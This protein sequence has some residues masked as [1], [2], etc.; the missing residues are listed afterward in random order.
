MTAAAIARQCG[1]LPPDAP[2]PY[3]APVMASI[4]EPGAAADDRSAPAAARTGGGDAA[5]TSGRAAAGDGQAAG[6]SGRGA[7]EVRPWS[8]N[9]A[10][11]SGQW[12]QAVLQ[13]GA[14]SSFLSGISNSSVQ[15]HVR[16]SVTCMELFSRL[17]LQL[18]DI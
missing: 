9:A 14:A 4:D 15:H 10:W 11:T 5:S 13:L 17:G 6:H 2:L 18:W 16:T 1:I 8:S 3:L 12:R 7:G